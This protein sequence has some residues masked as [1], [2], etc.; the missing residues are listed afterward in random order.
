MSTGRVDQEAGAAPPA[1][2]RLTLLYIFAL[3]TVAV[4]S[5]GAQWLI[6]R[7][8]SN[9]ESDSR[10]INTAGR[11]RMLSQKLAK[12]SLRVATAPAG[13]DQPGL[14]ELRATLN[15]WTRNHQGLQSG[16]PV[17][18][19]PG[20]NSGEVKRLFTVIEPHFR[21]MREAAE[22]LL[23]SDSPREPHLA[24]VLQ[25]ESDF[26]AG[27]D[28]IVSQ[29][30]TEAEL[31]VARLRRLEWAILAL[32]LGVLLIEGLLIFRPAVER[33]E[34]TVARLGAVSQRLLQAKEQAEEANAAKTRFLANVSHELRTPMTAV[35]GMTELARAERDDA[36]RRSYLS[37]VDEAG[38]SLLGLLNDL[39]DLAKIDAGQLS[40]ESAPL[41]PREVVARVARMMRSAATDKGLSLTTSRSIPELAVLGDAQRLEQVLLNLVANAIKSTDAGSVVLGCTLVRESAASVGLSFSVRDTGVGIDPADQ[42][43]VFEPF[44]QARD[45]AANGAAGA[46]LGLAICRRIAEAMDAKITLLSVPGVGTTV[47]LS[48]DFPRAPE[49]TAGGGLPLDHD[50]E[51][52]RASPASPWRV[53]V[54]EDTEVNRVLVREM[55]TRA[56]HSVVVVGDGDQAIGA[57]AGENFDAVLIDL[58]LP[59]IDGVETAREI[60]GVAANAGRPSPPMICVTAHVGAAQE[61][62]REHDFFEA[63]VTKPID[64]SAL[65]LTLQNLIEGSP[66]P[67]VTPPAADASLLDELAAAF[68]KACPEQRRELAAAIRARRSGDARVLSHRFRGQLAY[69]D[70]GRHATL[71]REFEQACEA[72]RHDVIDRLGP[73]VLKAIDSVVDELAQSRV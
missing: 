1:G 59:G 5:V 40:M 25:H 48:A 8:L 26:L 22:R 49:P 17:L 24:T 66:D 12:A 71:L 58:Q 38:Q 51:R 7:Q 72:N 37:I 13:A 56:G 6:Q 29:Y 2:R 61:G 3:S 21:A 52:V 43:K 9:G 54:V 11:Q 53:L 70:G 69:F 41:S 47:T 60:R 73:A 18:G 35:L 14:D 45:G 23:T 64:W 65:T 32:T 42:E 20:D 46:G 36:K 63:V 10:V 28:R 27:M 50:A 34:R 4:L 39:I 44:V 68:L 30:V 33:I 62:S 57:F 31:K 19:V 15:L 55:L 16:D 67:S